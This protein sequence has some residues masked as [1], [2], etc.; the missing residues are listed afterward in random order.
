[1]HRLLAVLTLLVLAVRPAFADP[2]TD[3]RNAMIALGR[4]TSYHINVTSEGRTMDGDVVNPG[5]MHLVV[6][7]MEMIVI[8]KTTYVKMQGTWRQF[9]M[10]G[11]DRMTAP[12]ARV[13]NLAKSGEQAQVT[14]LG[15][16]T[17]D[18]VALHAYLVKPADGSPSTVYLDDQGRIVRIES[19]EGGAMSVVRISNYNAPVTIEAP[20]V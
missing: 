20:P 3:V 6:A 2:T 18:G 12:I 11:A 13:Q 14:D 9:S 15:P 1:M 5:K 8:D 7:P 17:V 19:N 16:K 10:P 4:A